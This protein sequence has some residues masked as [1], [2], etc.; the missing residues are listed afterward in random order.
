MSVRIKRIY[1]APGDDDGYRVLV[2]RV[3]PR[4]VSKQTARLDRWLKEIAPS[5]ELRRWFGHDPSRW[6]EFRKRYRGELQE[7]PVLVQE[8]ADKARYAPVTLL[9]SAR[10]R[11][12]NQAVVLREWLEERLS[13]D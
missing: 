10:D 3:W 4:G 5:T 9:F 13:S 8:L 1:D 2:D 12:H 11:Q 6:N 7:T